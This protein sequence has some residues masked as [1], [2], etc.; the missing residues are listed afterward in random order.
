MT[1]S[2][3]A[4]VE[5]L[6]MRV[7][8]DPMGFAERVLGEL[9]ERLATAPPG[10]GPTVVPGFTMPNAAQPDAAASSP[11]EHPHQAL[12]DRSMLLAA[13]LGACDCWGEHGD[14]PTCGGE[15]S[16]GWVPPDPE[17]FVEYVA[18]AVRRSTV[19]DLPTPTAATQSGQ[20]RSEAVATTDGPVEGE[21]LP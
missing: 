14:C 15:G 1:T 7:L 3:L 19:T 18:P 11:G 6:L 9:L 20:T 8:P 17:L 12:L 5:M 10:S 13:A 16:A 4:T 2:E 21:E